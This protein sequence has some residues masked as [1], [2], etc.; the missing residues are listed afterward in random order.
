MKRYVVLILL[1][2]LSMSACTPKEGI[3]VRDAWMNPVSRGNN[4]AVYL[5][6]HNYNET[7][8]TVIGASS[9]LA[10][11]VELH[12]ST[13]VN[14]VV[15]MQL[16]E[17]VPLPAGETVEFTPGNLHI[18]LNNLKQALQIGETFNVTLHF[19]NSADVTVSVE[20]HTGTD[21][22]DH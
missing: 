18:T 15:Q 13:M 5:V 11:V 21:H 16:L 3:E 12:R 1:T 4:G 22:S 7:D 8:D 6:I 17:S 2:A 19:Q 9:A 20:V 10:D 14:D